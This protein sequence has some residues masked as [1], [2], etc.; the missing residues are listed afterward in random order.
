MASVLFAVLVTACGAAPLARSGAQLSPTVTSGLQSASPRPGPTVGSLTSPTPSPTPFTSPTAS[1]SPLVTPAPLGHLP[2]VATTLDGPLPISC[3]GTIGDNDPVAITF[4]HGQ[5]YPVLRDYSDPAHPRSVCSFG[6]NVQLRQILDP[7]HVVVQAPNYQTGVYVNLV[8]E[9]PSI[10]AYQLN[11]PGEL[12]AVAPDLSQIL[13]FTS[14]FTALHDSWDTGDVVIQRY[15]SPA[16]GRCGNA[17]TDSRSGSFSRDSHYGFALQGV[18]I[19]SEYLNV[20]GNRAGVFG[21][22]SPKGGWGPL[23][24]PLMAVWSPASDTLYYRK[25]G[26]IWHWT[27]TTG[28]AKFKA[29][30]S[31]IDPSISPNGKYIV[32][33]VRGADGTPT[34]HLMDAATGDVLSQLGTG[35][36]DVPFFLTNDLIWLHGDLSGCTG[37]VPT[38]Y[39]YDLRDHTESPSVI[40]WVQATWPA[41]SALG[42]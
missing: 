17:D 11:V 41:T 1:P 21:E 6:L 18:D 8:V 29:G 22:T 36:R 20:V 3:T 32:Y 35:S 26:D 40:D 5:S 12:A 7:H 28:S 13:W 10:T 25:Q 23:Y 24:G 14:D 33:T 15:P 9:L 34:V 27:P 38:N 16:G 42:G 2:I 19:G 31:W 39:I 37:S 4:L 30:V